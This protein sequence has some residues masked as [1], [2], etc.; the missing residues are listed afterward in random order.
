[1]FLGVAGVLV[2]FDSINVGMVD[3]LYLKAEAR[4]RN[5]PEAGSLMEIPK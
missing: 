5:S 3:Q 2:A 1:M 4:A